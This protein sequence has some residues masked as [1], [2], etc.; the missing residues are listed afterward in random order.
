MR[1]ET[2]P[3]HTLV[4]LR[5][6]AIGPVAAG[7]SPGQQ[8][9]VRDWLAKGRPFVRRRPIVLPESGLSL[10][11]PL[12]PAL[13]RARI[14]LSV[15][16]VLVQEVA[17]PPVLGDAL[18]AAPAAWQSPLGVLAAR[19]RDLG[20]LPRVYGSLAWQSLTGLEYLTPTSDI[21]LLFNASSRQQL[22]QVLAALVN[23]ERETG[24]R[25]DGELA[26]MDG[27]AVAW[28]ELLREPAQV[29]VK[30]L[31]GIELVPRQALLER[32]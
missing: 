16:T 24:L 8:I 2:L 27:C 19:L 5:P 21:D 9:Q 3:R 1:P 4:W 13:G 10:G 32:L 25:A 28:R 6:A 15:A 30:S 18:S 14:G 11:L 17:P 26:F 7:L 20:V 31:A 29:L 22:Q 12:P 23:W